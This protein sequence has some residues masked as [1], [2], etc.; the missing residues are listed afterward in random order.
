VLLIAASLALLAGLVMV[1][2]GFRLHQRHAQQR[3]G[4]AESAFVAALQVT[5]NEDKAQELLRRHLER[6]LAGARAVIL[7]RNNS[8]DRLE[9]RTPVEGVLDC[10]SPCPGVT[11]SGGST[12]FMAT[13]GATRRSLPSVSRCG[14]SFG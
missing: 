6:L 5:E 1:R 12:T 9:A 8:D 2:I 3:H 4:E 13:S 11:T 7:V 14:I 10:E